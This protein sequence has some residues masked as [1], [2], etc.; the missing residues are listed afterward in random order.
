MFD[1]DDDDDDLIW[2]MIYNPPGADGLRDDRIST[3]P[4]PSVRWPG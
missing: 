1:D 3:I 4:F 2:M